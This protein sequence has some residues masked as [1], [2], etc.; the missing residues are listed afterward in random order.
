MGISCLLSF[1]A[2]VVIEHVVCC[3]ERALHIGEYALLFFIQQLADNGGVVDVIAQ[4]L[5]DGLV[6]PIFCLFLAFV[7]E[8]S[9]FVYKVEILVYHIPHLGD[10]QF[11]VARVG[12]YFG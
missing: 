4:L 10:T 3:G 2:E 1:V 7:L 9:V 5:V 11:V 8:I 12:E 6:H